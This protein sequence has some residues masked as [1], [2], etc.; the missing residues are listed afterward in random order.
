MVNKRSAII[1]TAYV[2]QYHRFDHR[3]HS[4]ENENRTLDNNMLNDDELS[5]SADDDDDDDERYNEFFQSIRTQTGLG[6]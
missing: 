1:A 4:N 3:T 2:V 5:G 6:R